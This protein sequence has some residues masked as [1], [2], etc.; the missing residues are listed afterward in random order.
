MRPKFKTSKNIIIGAL[1]GGIIGTMISFLA[2]PNDAAIISTALGVFI[3]GVIGSLLNSDHHDSYL[4][5][6]VNNVKMSLR[7]EQ[8][9]ISKKRVKTAEVTMHTET[10]TEEKNI[11]VP[12]TREELVIESKALD[13]E[14]TETIRIPLRKER[15]DV[16]KYPVILEDVAISQKQFQDIHCV[17]KTLK[18]EKLNLETTGDVKVI[19]KEVK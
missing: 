18:K 19:D 5:D 1:I 13:T 14:Q 12:V 6:K 2:I 15:I 4:N 9:D 10:L 3:G 7:E 16:V 17:E 11:I 8:L